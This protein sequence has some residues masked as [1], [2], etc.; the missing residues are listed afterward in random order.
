M[1]SERG[2]SVMSM[3]LAMKREMAYRRHLELVQLIEDCKSGKL[4]ASPNVS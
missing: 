1:G 4:A 3:E 2:K